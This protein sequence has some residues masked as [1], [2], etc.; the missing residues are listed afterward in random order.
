MTRG[1][2]VTYCATHP[3]TVDME[4]SRHVS[5]TSALQTASLSR[6]GVHY[7]PP[8]PTMLVELLS[9]TARSVSAARTVRD[10]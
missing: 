10:A 9:A 6:S 8:R 7:S 4:T 2:S 5:E 1:V 3:T